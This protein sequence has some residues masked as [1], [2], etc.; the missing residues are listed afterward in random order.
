VDGHGVVTGEEGLDV[1]ELDEAAEELGVFEAGEALKEGVVEVEAKLGV[2]GFAAVAEGA[3]EDAGPV[4]VGFFGGAADGAMEETFIRDAVEGDKGGRFKALDLGL[5]AGGLEDDVGE[6]EEFET[7]FVFF[8]G[9][10]LEGLGDGLGVDALDGDV[11][12]EL[13]EAFEEFLVVAVAGVDDPETL[14]L[15]DGGD[16]AELVDSLGVDDFFLLGANFLEGGIAAGGL[17][18]EHVDEELVE[19]IVVDGEA[20]DGQIVNGEEALQA[21]GMMVGE[22]EE[23][24]AEAFAEFRAREFESLIFVKALAG[25]GG[26]EAIGIQ[27]ATDEEGPRRKE[28]L[29]LFGDEHVLEVEPVVLFGGGTGRVREDIGDAIGGTGLA[30]ERDGIE[31]VGIEE[32]ATV[33]Q[34]SIMGGG[35]RGA[36][37]RGLLIEL[38]A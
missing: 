19:L 34:E 29:G 36:P 9:E 13:G 27:D 4:F 38:E 3:I 1:D 18:G 26:A 5:A 11:G 37:G 6:V 35:I 28:A 24:A 30:M 32:G 7:R 15:G 14:G 25:G 20:L 12:E 22:V 23:P 16:L 8:E 17:E 10:V 2:G 21:L 31:E 33:V